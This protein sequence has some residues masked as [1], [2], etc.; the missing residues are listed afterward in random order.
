MLTERDVA[1]ADMEK[2]V[3]YLCSTYLVHR[4]T[5]ALCR[6][7]VIQKFFIQL[8]IGEKAGSGAD[9]IV[10]GWLDN[11]W[12]KPRL[13]EKVQPD[14]VMLTFELEE[15]NSNSLSPVCLQFVL[16]LS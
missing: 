12:G 1:E 6:N 14:V 9:F 13:E 8:G 11:K 5:F 3:N 2:M 7:P 16:S 15:V 10:K 4:M